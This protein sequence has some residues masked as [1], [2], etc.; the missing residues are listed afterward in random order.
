MRGALA[1]HERQ[2]QQ[3]AGGGGF[4]EEALSQLFECRELA[5]ASLYCLCL[6]FHPGCGSWTHTH[7]TQ[8]S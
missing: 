7:N 2:E 5:M 8:L 4:R 1:E 6:H 3:E